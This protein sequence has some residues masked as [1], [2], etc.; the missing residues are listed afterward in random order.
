MNKLEIVS[1]ILTRH[2]IQMTKNGTSETQMNAKLS[3]LLELY[4]DTDDLEKQVTRH[5]YRQ[6]SAAWKPRQKLKL[7]LRNRMLAPRLLARA[8]GDWFTVEVAVT[9]LV[10]CSLN[11]L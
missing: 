7:H 6:N 2:E 3:Q 11:E 5:K 4:P 1:P 8:E 10:L 9:D